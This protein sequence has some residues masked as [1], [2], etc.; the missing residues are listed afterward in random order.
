MSERVNE[1]QLDGK[2]P[3]NATQR[4]TTPA[5]M[6]YPSI[7]MHVF[8]TPICCALIPMCKEEKVRDGRKGD[9]E[10]S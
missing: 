9:H 4:P 10:P 3:E 7:P 8:Q 1:V 2:A 5:E 6:T